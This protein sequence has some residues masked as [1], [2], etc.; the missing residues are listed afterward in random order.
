MKKH[1]TKKVQW[2]YFWNS[3]MG[4][5]YYGGPNAYEDIQEARMAYQAAGHKVGPILSI[6]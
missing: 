1:E 4:N 2:Y 3:L 5:V 6:P